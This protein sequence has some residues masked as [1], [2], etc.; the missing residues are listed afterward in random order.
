[1][2]AARQ[3]TRDRVV[4]AARALKSRFACSKYEVGVGFEIMRN[5][6]ATLLI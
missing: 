5:F 6:L 1:M 2:D 4:H 3:Q